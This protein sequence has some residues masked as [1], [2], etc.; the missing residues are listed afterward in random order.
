MDV[1][2]QTLAA[3]WAQELSARISQM[4]STEPI[5][6][7]LAEAQFQLMRFVAWHGFESKSG[8]GFRVEV[9]HHGQVLDHVDL[10]ERGS[11]RW[12]PHRARSMK[13]LIPLSCIGKPLAIHI[14]TDEDQET[15]LA[16][17]GEVCAAKQTCGQWI[18]MRSA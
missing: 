17:S 8:K 9:K 7:S 15:K 18:K 10:H 2:L 16:A 1:E 13:L 6:F 3:Q 12:V 14:L 11:S 4:Q 5:F